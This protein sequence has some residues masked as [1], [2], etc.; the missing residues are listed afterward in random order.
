MKLGCLAVVLLFMLPFVVMSPLLVDPS[1]LPAPIGDGLSALIC[2]GGELTRETFRESYHRPGEVGVNIHCQDANGAVTDGT[3]RFVLVV[4]ASFI[5]PFGLL[6]IL[7]IFKAG[8]L[9]QNVLTHNAQ[10]GVNFTSSTHNMTVDEFNQVKGS[11]G[12]GNLDVEALV[13]QHG[14]GREGASNSLASQLRDL[15]TSY[16]EGLINREEYD[17]ARQRILSNLGK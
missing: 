15:E 2:G 5:L 4:F 13:K 9:T 1:D 7:S 10:Q 6:M 8:K 12:L 16:K 3:G 11:L 17:D 14:G